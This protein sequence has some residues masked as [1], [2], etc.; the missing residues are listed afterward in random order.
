[1][2]SVGVVFASY[3]E[4]PGQR[5]RDHFE[6]NRDIY[7]N[8]LNDLRVY[9]VTDRP[10]SLPGYAENVVIPIGE[11]PV[12]DSKARF[13]LAMAKNRGIKA[14]ADGVSVIIATDVD[15]A[16]GEH[17]FREMTFVG[18]NEAVVPVYRMVDDIKDEYSEDQ[19]EHGCTGTVSMSPV[20]W[21]RIRY[22]E[23]CVGYGGEDGILLR[24]IERTPLKINRNCQVAH[25]AHIAGDKERAPGSGSEACWGR[26][27]GFNFDNFAENR[28]HHKRRR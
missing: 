22:N 21:S 10:Y 9:V 28:K 1:M 16:F 11:M 13:S 25:V 24:K 4:V 26:A 12:V 5:L 20:N 27:S 7:E 19:L 15:V 14:V 6:W 8:V 2:P 17:A 23:N 18:Q 3:L